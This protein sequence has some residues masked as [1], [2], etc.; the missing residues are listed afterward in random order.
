MFAEC[1]VLWCSKI[2]T[3]IALIKTKSGY[4][5]LSQAIF[6]I[7]PFIVLLKEVFFV[8]NIH[9]PKIDVFC[10]VFKDNKR[11]IALVQSSK[12]SYQKHYIAIKYRHLGSFIQNNLICILYIDTTEQTT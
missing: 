2:K 6:N 10:K 12:L 3:E 9:L 1:T 8:F 7:L 5:S 11:C 4:I